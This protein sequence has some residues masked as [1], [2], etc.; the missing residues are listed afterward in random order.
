MDADNKGGDSSRSCVG[1]LWA[2]FAV[3]HPHF[4][5]VIILMTP[6]R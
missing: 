5:L 3:G 2:W 4:L 6:L 1:L